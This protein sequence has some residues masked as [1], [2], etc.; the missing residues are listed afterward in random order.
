MSSGS[1]PSPARAS[2]VAGR[3]ISV[4]EQ[5]FSAIPS[6][7]RV[8]AM[9]R[10]KVYQSGGFRPSPAP[11]SDSPPKGFGVYQSSGFRPSPANGCCDRRDS[12]SVLESGSRPFPARRVHGVRG[13]EV[14]QS[15]GFRP[16]PACTVRFT[17]RR[18][19][20]QSSGFRPSPARVSAGGPRYRSVSEQRFSAIPSEFGC[21]VH[22]VS[23]SEQ[24]FS[25]IPS[26]RCRLVSATY[27]VSE[28]RF[29]AI[30]SC[31]ISSV[32]ADASVYQSSG[33]RPSPAGSRKRP[34]Q[35]PP[36]CIRAAVFGHPQPIHPIGSTRPARV[37]QSSGFLGHPQRYS[38]GCRVA[39]H[40]A[41][42]DSRILK[43]RKTPYRRRS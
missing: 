33:F 8:Q 26:L 5:R 10:R 34:G 32:L 15:S 11:R 30:P 9:S 14:Y 19:V 40:R 27:S 17:F 36:E 37:Y 12:V 42:G 20:Y 4:S 7:Y 35:A 38:P 16:S 6:L 25:A 22:H 41:A 21:L 1:R 3:R 2:T 31:S 13:F 43:T 39:P 28:Q 24:R 18:I 23:V 29:S